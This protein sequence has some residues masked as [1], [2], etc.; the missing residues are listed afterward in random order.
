MIFL[1]GL[2]GDTPMAAVHEALERLDAPIF[3]LD[4]REALRT[5]VEL[6]VG[7]EVAGTVRIGG[8][9]LDLG[10]VTAA[11]PRPYDSSKLP[12][13]K[14]AGPASPEARH[15]MQLDDALFSW[16]EI[17]PALVINRAS[18]GAANGSKPYQAALIEPH[19]FRTPETLL[20]TD[21][22]AAR[23]FLARHGTIIY[24]SISGIRSIVS[25]FSA[26]HDERLAALRWCPTQFQ[27][28]VEGDDYRVHVIGQEVFASRIVTD[29]DDYRYP[30]RQGGRTSVEPFDAPPE[31]AEKC[32]RMAHA[33]AL[34]VAGIDLRRTPEGEWYCFEV[35][36]SPG[37]T[38]YQ[39]ECGFPMDEAIARLLFE[40]RIP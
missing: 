31:L 20:T 38:Y 17:T 7:M 32:K 4:Q 12:D 2:P 40:G 34:P 30:R 10:A 15:V 9:T 22:E 19:G 21:P 23:E 6:E 1:W 35:N 36:P 37:F 33:M 3:F 5:E 28:R 14:R 26:K 29:V 16:C 27:E 25:R 13:V 24:K 8:R 18:A 39:E 11:Y